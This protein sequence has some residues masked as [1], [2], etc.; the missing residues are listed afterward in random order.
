[1]SGKPGRM[2]AGAILEQYGWALIPGSRLTYQHASY[3]AHHIR[4][5]IHG[6]WEHTITPTGTKRRQCCIAYGSGPDDLVKHLNLYHG[7][8]GKINLVEDQK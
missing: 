1:M 8:H 3:K 2:G 4:L 6:D 5:S 7:I